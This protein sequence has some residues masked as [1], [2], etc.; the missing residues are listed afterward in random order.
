M[1]FPGVWSATCDYVGAQGPC[2]IWCHTNQSGMFC[3]LVPWLCP[4][5]GNIKGPFLNP[6]PYCSQSLCW[7][8]C[9]LLPWDP[10]GGL[11]SAPKGCTTTGTILIWLV[12]TTSWGHGGCSEL[13]CSEEYVWVNGTTA[14]WVCVEALSQYGHRGP[15]GGP[16][17]RTQSVT[18]LESGG[19]FAAK[20]IKIWVVC[21]TSHG[22]CMV[23][24]HVATECL[25]SGQ[26][27]ESSLVVARDMQIQVAFW[28][29]L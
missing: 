24:S 23:W 9:P 5:Q 25:G 10:C 6:R 29:M 1:Y 11:R 7:Y 13:C 20:S 27:P 21:V 17:P 12:Y 4:G 28:P 2:W 15:H 18:F 8:Q 19:H 16:R 26:P 14:P 3:Y 22:H